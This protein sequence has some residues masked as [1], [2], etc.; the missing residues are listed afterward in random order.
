MQS[1]HLPDA[2]NA[3]NEA[4]AGTFWLEKLCWK[5]W[6][7]NWVFPPSK[8]NNCSALAKKR[9]FC[10]EEAQNLLLVKMDALAVFGVSE[11]LFRGSQRFIADDYFTSLTSC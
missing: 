11:V 10:Q 5:T 3:T 8:Y 4:A 2:P 6:L 9:E 7:V 1:Q